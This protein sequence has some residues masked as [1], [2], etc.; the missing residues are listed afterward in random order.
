MVMAV[1]CRLMDRT[2]SCRTIYIDSAAA[3]RARPRPWSRA[4]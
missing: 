2:S 1:N 3:C 4:W